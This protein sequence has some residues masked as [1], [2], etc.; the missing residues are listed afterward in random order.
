MLISAITTGWLLAACAGGDTAA[1]VS[2]I[3][4][5]SGDETV[6]VPVDP[7]PRPDGREAVK[8]SE[9]AAVDLPPLGFEA[10]TETQ[11]AVTIYAL[12][13]TVAPC[14]PCM[15]EG[16]SVARCLTET[17]PTCGNLMDVARRGVRSGLALP[18]EEHASEA[19]LMVLLGH[20]RYEEPWRDVAPGAMAALPL[21]AGA[22]DAPIQVLLVVDYQDPFSRQVQDD[23]AALMS[24]YG[25]RIGWRL[26]Q[27]P[28]VERHLLSERAAL[29]VLAAGRQGAALAAHEALLGGALS[30]AALDGIAAAAGLDAARLTEDL[31]D[32]A[33][34]KQLA[35]DRTLADS[36]DVRATPS[37]VAGGYLVRGARVEA[38]YAAMLDD[39]LADRAD[40]WPGE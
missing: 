5:S 19:E 28:D 38:H 25:E 34:R 31:A 23:W 9:I 37:T 24:R 7:N 20:I 8:G 17:H 39:L 33:L 21:L 26:V 12:N 22:A 10:L 15:G 3:V 2:R 29:T 30:E 13:T 16:T 32:P 36:L 35:A 6:Q 18:L 27:R 1:P 40:S 4:E 11:A 14:E